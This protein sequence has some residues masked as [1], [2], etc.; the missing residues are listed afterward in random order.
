MNLTN[1]LLLFYSNQD[2][3]NRPLKVWSLTSVVLETFVTRGNVSQLEH[4]THQK[5]KISI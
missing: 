5:Q 4:M 2:N 3:A 1:V